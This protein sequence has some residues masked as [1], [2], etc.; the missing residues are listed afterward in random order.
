MPDGYAPPEPLRR[1]IVGVESLQPDRDGEV[2]ALLTCDC[3]TATDLTVKTGS[4]VA[5]CQEAAFTCSGCQTPH[6]FEIH[7]TPD[8]P[9]A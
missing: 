1:S 5:D 8:N 3:G 6:W 4:E 9:A 2:R 7:A